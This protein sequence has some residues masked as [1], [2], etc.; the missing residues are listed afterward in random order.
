MQRKYIILVC[1]LAM[2]LTGCKLENSSNGKLDGYW[3]LT[4]I[5]D[6]AVPE[7]SIDLRNASIFWCVQ[8]NLIVVRD[9]EE[10]SVH[11]YVFRFHQ[12]DDE[13]RLSDAQLYD[14]KIGNTTVE[15]ISVLSKYGIY[16][17]PET[18]HIDRLKSG[19]M[20]LSTS[21]HRLTFEK[22]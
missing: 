1:L 20:I 10:T 15:D 16:N 22:F 13:L 17:Q 12:T 14:K 7:N 3:K 5:E 19:K 4:S 9:N 6:T 2:M 21:D 18:F 11:E 8:K